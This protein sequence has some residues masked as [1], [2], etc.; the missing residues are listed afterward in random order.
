MKYTSVLSALLLGA[1]VAVV[2]ATT[3][4][5]A[6]A[7]SVTPCIGSN[8]NI[9]DNV[10]GT[11]A[12]EIGTANQDF[13]NTNPITVNAE[14]FF[15]FTDWKY[16]SRTDLASNAGQSGT[17]SIANF[18]QNTWTDAML[19]FKD[20]GDTTLVG[21]LLQDGILS[22]SWTSPFEEPPFNFPGRG[23]RDV[24]HISVYYREGT[25]VPEPITMFGLGV[26]LVGGGVLKQKYGKKANKEKVTA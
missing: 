3:A 26:G 16:S 15:G 14:Q 2:T 9:A 25:P 6:Q 13:L 19:I 17:W 22:G 7:I 8:Y 12:C 24:S 21:Y 18:I 5:P 23:P 11:T 1:S 4:A 10:T 20:G